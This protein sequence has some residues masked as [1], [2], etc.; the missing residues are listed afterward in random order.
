LYKS[1]SSTTLTLT[2]N[3]TKQTATMKFFSSALAIALCFSTASAFAPHLTSTTATARTRTSFDPNKASAACGPSVLF[4]E[5][6]RRDFQTG[7]LS[8]M[9][10]GGALSSRPKQAEAA[11]AEAATTPLADVPM[12]RLKLPRGGFGREYVA[13]KLNVQGSGPYDFMVDSGLTLEMITPHLQRMLGIDDGRSRLSGLAAGGSTMSNPLVPLNGASIANDG[14]DLVLPQLTAAVTSF[15]QEHID[16]AHDPVEGMLG[17]EI[18]QQFD[19]DF[20]FPKNRLRFYKPGTADTS[21]LVDIPAVVINE[22]LLI[23]VRISTPEGNT[24]PIIGLLDCGSSFSC[25][26]WKAAEALG[27]PPK[28]D[29]SY[30]NAPGVQAIGIDGRPLFLPT[31]KKQ[32]SFVGDPIVEDGRPVGFEQ[33]PA[34]WKPWNPVQ[35]AVGDIPVF[36]QILGDGV[37]PYEGPAA[38]IGLDILAQRRVIL[39]AGNSRS[40]VRKVAVSPK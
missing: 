20:D 28:T 14:A 7:L 1:A 30:R 13:L 35:L 39:E 4:A 5:L 25:V 24:Q 6:P 23:G 22:S 11:S 8:G 3:I 34:N 36:T 32:L 9:I 38:L 19:V 10:G 12:V 26:N 37:R 40:R 29:P 17:M 27:L 2:Q 15:P 33:P 16:P 21:G 31:V 18:L